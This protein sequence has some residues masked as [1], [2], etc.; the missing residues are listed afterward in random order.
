MSGF[1]SAV[2]AKTKI[3]LLTF[4]LAM[5]LYTVGV[6]AIGMATSNSIVFTANF[7]IALTGS[8]ASALSLYTVK[9]MWQ[10]K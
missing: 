9:R 3:R 7:V 5:E 4:M 10:P 2:S 1:S 6:S 8:L